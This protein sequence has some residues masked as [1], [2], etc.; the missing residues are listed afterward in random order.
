VARLPSLKSE[1]IDSSGLKSFFVQEK[2]HKTGRRMKIP[3]SRQAQFCRVL[4]FWRL[5]KSISCVF[6][7]RLNIS[8]PPPA[9]FFSLD[10]LDFRGPDAVS[11]DLPS[12]CLNF[13]HVLRVRAEERFVCV[14]WAQPSLCLP[15]QLSCVV[16]SSACPW[17]FVQR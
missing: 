3:R 11:V 7:I 1:S 16:L 14:I 4:R 2:L 8:I 10:S 13:S 17:W 6:S 5:E 12:S 15:S 9:P